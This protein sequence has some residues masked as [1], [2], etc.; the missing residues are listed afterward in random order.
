MAGK[1]DDVGVRTVVFVAMDDF[2]L[3]DLAGPLD[4]VRAASLLG[5]DPPYRT[6][7]ATPGGRSV[8]SESG[9][10]VGA[11][12]SVHALATSRDP[13]DTLVVVGGVGARTLVRDDELRGDLRL[14]AGRARR[15]TSVC[16]GA[17]LLAAAGLLDGYTATTHW[18]F[19]SDLA[20]GHPEVDVLPDR[21]Y[22]R[23]RDRWTSAGVTAGID[24]FLALVED[25]C[26]AELA[27]AI[28]G[29][30]VVFVRRPGGQA[31]FSAQL[32]SQPA[33]SP[34]I[35]ELQRWL[36]D[37]L[38]EDLSVDT[39]ADRARMSSRTFARTFAAETGTT[40]AAYV[41]ELRVEAA[42]RLLESS[43]L[44]V[45]T[46]AKRVGFNRPETLYRAFRRRVAT[47]PD[48]Y[49]QHFARTSA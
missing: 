1:E 22:V 28:A 13:V 43:D 11:D 15:T 41:E 38:D 25:D 36:P 40:P 10:L 39:L 46:V 26:G 17:A 49:R 44:T 29:W 20:G 35:G 32:R 19:C 37:H 45:E 16:T 33:R 18:A 30:L 34:A 27:H 21:I 47:T 31:Q 2:Q 3:L 9:L 42:R 24:L 4:V 23:D 7:V 48:R 6:V 8:R 14:I 5:A 12:T